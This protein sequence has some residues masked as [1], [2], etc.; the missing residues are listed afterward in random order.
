M[1][2]W[3][4]VRFRSRGSSIPS[5]D[6]SIGRIAQDVGFWMHGS[7]RGGESA[8]A[9]EVGLNPWWCPKREDAGAAVGAVP[10]SLFD[11]CSWASRFIV[12]DAAAGLGS[13]AA[14]YP[15]REVI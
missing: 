3:R 11:S 4:W 15:R 1:A 14:T 13:L 8:A 10:R 6:A 12:S 7:R 5:V 9:L 2:I